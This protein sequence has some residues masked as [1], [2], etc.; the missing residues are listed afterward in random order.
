M[1]NSMFLSDFLLLKELLDEKLVDDC[2]SSYDK[3]RR[4]DCLKNHIE[5]DEDF[6]ALCDWFLEK[7][8]SEDIHFDNPDHFYRCMETF[9]R[10]MWDAYNTRTGYVI[11]SLHKI[12][13]TVKL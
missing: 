7:D 1:R 4:D 10:M 9:I 8:R 12:P 11:T 13:G 6:H 5:Y 2:V 3:F